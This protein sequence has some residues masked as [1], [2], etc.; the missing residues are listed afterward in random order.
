MLSTLFSGKLLPELVEQVGQTHIK[1]EHR[2]GTQ[3]ILENL[4]VREGLRGSLVYH[5]WESGSV[6]SD[7]KV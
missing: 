7:G 4:S 3:L 5:V 2:K 1:A 6:C